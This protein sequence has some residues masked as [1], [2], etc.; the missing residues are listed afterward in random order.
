MISKK[1]YS[2]DLEILK[3]WIYDFWRKYFLDFT[4]IKS[5]ESHNITCPTSIITTKNQTKEKKNEGVI[6]R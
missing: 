1:G 4:E 5:D 2:S 6:I 3:M